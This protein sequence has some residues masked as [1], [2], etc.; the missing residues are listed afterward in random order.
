MDMPLSQTESTWAQEVK[1]VMVHTSVRE[2]AK[3]L[4][5]KV[6]LLE[7]EPAEAHWAQEV[8][9]EKFHN[10]S[11][12][13]TDGAWRLVVSEMEHREQFEELSLLRA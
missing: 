10:L 13:S 5:C 11:D 3:G 9:K 4:F 6:A 12:A 7:G 1:N 8:T 2:D